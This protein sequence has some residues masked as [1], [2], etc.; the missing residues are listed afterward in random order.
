MYCLVILE[1]LKRFFG[2]ADFFQGA[3]MLNRLLNGTD[4]A[5]TGHFPRI[6][7]CDVKIRAFGTDRAAT[8]QCM[9]IYCYMYCASEE[10]ARYG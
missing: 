3:E 2:Y 5:Q 1:L 10:S 7:H 8:V 9:S 6:T 4:W